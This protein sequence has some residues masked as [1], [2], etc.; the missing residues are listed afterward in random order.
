MNITKWVL[1][2]IMGFVIGFI[3]CYEFFS[4][5]DIILPKEKEYITDSIKV[6]KPYPVPKPYPVSVKPITVIIYEKDSTALDSLKVLLSEKDILIQGLKSEITISQDYLKQF[7]L[8]PKL[9]EMGL[10]RDSLFLSLLNIR[11]VVC[12]Q[13]YPI[14]LD[15]YRYNWANDSLGKTGYNPP[16]VGSVRYNTLLAGGGLDIWQRTAYT[17]VKFESTKNR[18]TFYSEFKLSIPRYKYSSLNLGVYFKIKQ[19]GSGRK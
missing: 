8:N 19:Y 3:T 2:I 7:P 4:K 9:I 10:I 5:G 12:K 17:S 15:R 6:L 11:G 18:T 13:L 14:F 16:P 1:V